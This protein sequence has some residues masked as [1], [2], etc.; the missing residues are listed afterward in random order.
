M[1]IK[2][3]E[4]EGLVEAVFGVFAGVDAILD[5]SISPWATSELIADILD[6]RFEEVDAR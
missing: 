6:C 3:L 2:D 4:E 5:D 1:R